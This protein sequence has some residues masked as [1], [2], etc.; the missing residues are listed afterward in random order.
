M[1]RTMDIA[2]AGLADQ[3]GA[4]VKRSV[5]TR[6]ALALAFLVPLVVLG[7]S[8]VEDGEL[9]A[10]S[11]VRTAGLLAAAVGAVTYVVYVATPAK[12]RQLVPPERRSRPS[13]VHGRSGYVSAAICR[14]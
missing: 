13:S 11:V 12:F 2:D 1:T 3:L 9:T 6:L 4:A 14:S 10:S 7:F 5:V 8:D